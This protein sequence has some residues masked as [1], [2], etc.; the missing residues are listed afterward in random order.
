MADLI[1]SK[2][3]TG[4]GWS[5]G[6]ASYEKY[7]APATKLGIERLIEALFK[8]HPPTAESKFLD[9]GAGTG[10]STSILRERHPF[11]PITALDLSPGMIER[12]RQLGLSGVKLCVGDAAAMDRTQIPRDFFTHVVAA[13]MIQFSGDKQPDV[14]REFY[15]SLAP[16]GVAG[17]SL[18]TDINIAEPWNRACA[19]LDP[20]YEPSYVHDDKAWTAPEQLEAGMREAGFEDIQKVKVWMPMFTVKTKEDYV[21]FWY[22]GNHPGFSIRD[23]G[24]WKG[25]P[26]DVLPELLKVLGEYKDLSNDIGVASDIVLGRKPRLSS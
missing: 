13:L 8:M 2:A 14:V 17:I 7:L 4:E 11:I 10:I 6:S 12:I 3:A 26:D 5:D 18:S 19:R 20:A 24:A 25:N 21:D 23:M 22:R 15:D 16:G 9:C 1:I